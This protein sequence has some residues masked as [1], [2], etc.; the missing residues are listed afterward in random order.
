MNNKSVNCLIDTGAV[1]NFISE[2]LVKS[3]AFFDKDLEVHPSNLAVKLA[4]ESIVRSAG[5][6]EIPLKIQGDIFHV[7][8]EIMPRLSFDLILGMEFLQK[9]KVVIDCGAR[10]IKLTLDPAFESLA[11]LSKEV[12]IPPFSEVR[13]ELSV[14]SHGDAKPGLTLLIEAWA[15]LRERFGISVARGIAQPDLQGHF[16]VTLANLS[17][18]PIILQ[19]KTIIAVVED[20]S[21]AEQLVAE[22]DEV[23]SV[24]HIDAFRRLR[25]TL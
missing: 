10:T 14:V 25:I 2:D 21:P 20:F 3:S 9:Q 23:T 6:A 4:D 7:L 13:A 15:P 5:R 24:E 8:V 18:A 11:E 19:I 12:S 17:Q 1:R 22:P 16:C